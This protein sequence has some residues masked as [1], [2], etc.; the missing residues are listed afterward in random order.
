MKNYQGIPTARLTSDGKASL[1]QRSSFH[2]IV[3]K[4]L[5]RKGYTRIC[6]NLFLCCKLEVVWVKLLSLLLTN[7]FRISRN[8]YKSHDSM[9]LLRSNGNAWFPLDRNGIVKSCDSGRF[10]VLEERFIKIENK[11][12]TKTDSDL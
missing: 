2:M 11:Y 10:W 8:E 3:I 6:T 4:V 7:L 1:Q 5:L 12:L 9:I